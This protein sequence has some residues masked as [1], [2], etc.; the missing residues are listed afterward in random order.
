MN[1]SSA[2]TGSG[3]LGVDLGPH[4]TGNPIRGGGEKLAAVTS[5]HTWLIIVLALAALWLLGGGVFRSLRMS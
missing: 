1:Q 3:E 2:D 4:A 5:G